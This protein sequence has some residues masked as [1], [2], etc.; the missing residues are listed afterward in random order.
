MQRNKK[1]AR[2]NYYFKDYLS[3]YIKQQQQQQQRFLIN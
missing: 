2:D 1:I 3:N